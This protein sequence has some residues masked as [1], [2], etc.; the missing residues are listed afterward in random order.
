VSPFAFRLTVDFAK[1]ILITVIM[2]ISPQLIITNISQ[3]A[4]PQG[5]T[6]LTTTAL[7][8]LRLESNPTI[9][10]AA[11]KISAILT[12]QAATDYLAQV[13]PA[14]PIVDAAQGV[15][16]PGLI[17]AHTHLVF[18]GNRAHEY[19]LRLQGHS[20]QEIAAK[21]G[22]IRYTVRQTR[23]QSLTQ[24]QQQAQQHLAW[25]L[26]SGTTTAEVKSGYGLSLDSEL[27]I[28][29]TIQQLQQE[30]PIELVPTFLGAHEIPDEYRQ[31]RM[32]YIDLLI[33]ELIPAVAQ[34]KLAE[35]CDIFCETHVFSVSEARQ[36]L[37]V[38]QQHGLQLR[39]HADQLTLNGGAQLA[40]ELGATTADHLEQIDAAGIDALRAAKV[41]A[42]LLPGSVFH[43]GLTRYPP[44][45]EM[46]AAGVAIALATDFNP[47][48]SPTPNLALIMSLACTQM[49][50]TPAESLTACTLNAACSLGRGDHLGSVEVGKQADLTIFQC[51]DYRQIPYFFG[52]PLVT[53][54]IKQGR[55]VYPAV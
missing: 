8:Q 36:I 22:G 35:Y 16:T 6:P 46:I 49:R 7:G 18:G 38:A 55:V 25:M 51:A 27:K 15:V 28:L 42:V 9:V 39:L 3:L 48:S 4:T 24:L 44:A 10:C 23:A 17:D 14:T 11:G 30:A 33:N 21:G 12:G 50:L 31:D 45:R 26:A 5:T 20:Y 53:T 13:D 41:I 1:T 2:S 29:L 52:A 47:G 34:A 32:A 40:A 19:E 37:T 43:L 54:V